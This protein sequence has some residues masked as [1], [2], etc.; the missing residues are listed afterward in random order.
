MKRIGYVKT[1]SNK[2]EEILLDITKKHDFID[3]A[4]QPHETIDALIVLGGDGF[5][6]HNIN[7]YMDKKIPIY[8]INCGSVGFLLNNYTKGSNL[9]KIID[10]AY[11]THLIPLRIKTT[12]TQDNIHET[13][14][15]NEVSIFRTTPQA[16][17]VQVKINN[18]VQFDKL[19][20][21]GL[22]I[23]TAA[24]SSAYNFSAGG[25]ILPINSRLISMTGI[26]VFRP[27]RWKNALLTDSVN[28]ALKIIDPSNRAA[29][30]SVDHNL[31][32]D[33]EKI[34]I[35]SDVQNSI[36]LLFDSENNLEKKIISE[37]FLS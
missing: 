2:A 3:L 32:H 8:G 15:A 4:S 36:S 28:I 23:S 27:R 29:T 16:C 9:H 34:E 6:L 19:I 30:V 21:D 7:Q 5:M 11:V 31:L 37:Q 20:G 33:V 25:P 35:Y 18:V 13:T 10:D 12:D 22:L 1:N 17:C 26:N 14:A 24:G